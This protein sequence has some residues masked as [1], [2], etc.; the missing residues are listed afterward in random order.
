[1]KFQEQESTARENPRV[2]THVARLVSII[3]L[4]VRAPFMYEGKETKPTHKFDFTYELVNSIMEDGRP[5][6]VSEEVPNKLTT[7]EAK[8]QSKLTMRVQ[9]LQGDLDNPKSLLGKPCMVEVA[10]KNEWPRITNVSGM[11]EGMPVKELQN[12][13][14]FFDLEAPDLTIFDSIPEYKQKRV[15]ANVNYNGSKLQQALDLQVGTRDDIA[16]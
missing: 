13:V 11:P 12:S 15:K 3:D 4:G 2:G 6:F 14:T 9:S 5:H 1:M 8:K 7:P 10:I 16:F